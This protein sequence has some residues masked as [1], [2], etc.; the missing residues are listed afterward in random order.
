MGPAGVLFWFFHAQTLP[1]V[2]TVPF[3]QLTRLG[4][5]AGVTRLATDAQETRLGV[6]SRVSR[7]QTAAGPT[8]IRE[9]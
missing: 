3:I 9:T 8:R 1:F 5:E 4:V 2:P 7:F 6:P